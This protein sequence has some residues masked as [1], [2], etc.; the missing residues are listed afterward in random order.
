MFD[1]QQHPP[2]LPC[3][4]AAGEESLALPHAAVVIGTGMPSVPNAGH[5]GG[6][7]YWLRVA[8]TCLTYLTTPWQGLWFLAPHYHSPEIFLPTSGLG[9]T[10]PNLSFLHPPCTLCP[11]HAKFGKV[12]KFAV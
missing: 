6:L 5:L 4:A 2:L 9:P 11:G 8:S 12:C 7:A 1:A 3:G 10:H